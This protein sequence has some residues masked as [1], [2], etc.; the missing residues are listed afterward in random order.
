MA[1]EGARPQNPVNHVRPVE[2][3]SSICQRSLHKI[4]LVVVYGFQLSVDGIPPIIKGAQFLNN[5]FVLLVDFDRLFSVIIKCG[6]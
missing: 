6:I 5:S 1:K 3:Y 2:K 4:E